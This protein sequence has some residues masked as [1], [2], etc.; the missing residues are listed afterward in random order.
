MVRAD[1]AFSAGGDL[2][3]VEEI[4]NDPEVRRRVFHEA[5]DLVYDIA[6][7]PRRSCRR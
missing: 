6:R 2:D 3:L 4:A 7:L 5:R 1:S